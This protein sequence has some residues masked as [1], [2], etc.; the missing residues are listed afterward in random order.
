MGNEMNSF[1]A[2][3]YGTAQTV[4]PA[5]PDIEKIAQAEVMQQYLANEGIDLNSLS[6]YQADVI[7][8]NLFGGEKVA[9]AQEVTQHPDFQWADFLGRTM[10]HSFVQEQ[11]KIASGAKEFLSKHVGSPMSRYREAA[12]GVRDAFSK[13]ETLAERHGLGEVSG[14]RML[15]ARARSLGG[16]VKKVI[17]EV[18]AGTAA[19]YGAKKL[20]DHNKKSS[21][22]DILAE[23]R[24]QEILAAN[25]I[26]VA[27]D[28][29][30]EAVEQRAHEMLVAA[31]YIQG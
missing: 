18:I 14:D 17:P 29:L 23:Q 13:A 24:A 9:S 12:S 22:I 28:P 5:G 16:A 27:S 3:L 10:A 11:E 15:G 25:G 7:A 31:G 21:A 2:D 6:D 1:L 19:A 30:Q 20:Y 26:K 8:Q 4:E